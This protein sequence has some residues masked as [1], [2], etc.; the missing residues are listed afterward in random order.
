MT[1][2]FVP[3]FTRTLQTR[4]REAAW[5]LGNL[6]INALLVA[7]GAIVVARHRVRRIP[8]TR[9]DCVGR[10]VRGRRREAR[11]HDAAD[12]DH[13]AVPDDRR[14]RGGGDGDA[15]RAA[16]VLSAGA[17]ARDVQRGDHP[18][19]VPDRPADAADRSAADCRHRDRHGPRRPRRRSPSSGRRLRKEGFRY[20]PTLD[21]R[22]PDRAARSC[23]LMG[24]GDARPRRRSDQRARQHLARDDR[25]AGRRVVAPGAR[26]G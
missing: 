17:V 10:R 5:R 9:H 7:T 4:G 14:G 24:P 3:T 11:A 6:V 12:P 8:I 26:S 13:D 1:A 19:R 22:D 15:E 21:F 25:A 23:A 20:R 18:G 16:P 2:A